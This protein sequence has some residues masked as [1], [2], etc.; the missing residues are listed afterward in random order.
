MY[1]WKHSQPKTTARSSRSMLVY[2]CS[3][4]VRALLAKAIGRPSW[5]RAAPIPI[6]DAST[7]MVVGLVTSKYVRAM[8]LQMEALTFSKPF[9]RSCST[10]MARPSWSELSEG[11]F[12]L[13]AWRW[14]EPWTGLCR[15]TAEFLWHSLERGSLGF[16]CTS[17]GQGARH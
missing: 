10:Q 8:S 11:Q 6:F 15:E 2:G 7:C 3:V 13:Q 4:S 9:C 5:R 14:M 16:Q 17:P 1:V 12:G